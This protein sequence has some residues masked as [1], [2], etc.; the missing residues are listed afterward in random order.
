M[1]KLSGI[2][3]GLLVCTNVWAYSCKV[4]PEYS[5]DTYEGRATYVEYAYNCLLKQAK[6]PSQKLDVLGPMSDVYLYYDVSQYPIEIQKLYTPITLEAIY[7]QIQLYTQ[8]NLEFM[9]KWYKDDVKDY[10]QYLWDEYKVVQDLSAPKQ[11]LF[12]TRLV[13]LTYTLHT[14]GVL[15]DYRALDLLESHLLC[16]L[17]YTTSEQAFKLV[18]NVAVN[19]ADINYNK[20]CINTPGQIAGI[21]MPLARKKG[22]QL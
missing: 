3:L 9:Y 11:V 15:K 8:D 4:E 1:K 13:K 10:Y 17:K 5:W 7:N 21:G 6:T 18:Y 2:V 19:M 20:N 12:A 22:F 16:F 14:N